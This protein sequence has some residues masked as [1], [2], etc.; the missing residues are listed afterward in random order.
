MSLVSAVNSASDTPFKTTTTSIKKETVTVLSTTETK[1]PPTTELLDEYD[2]GE[3]ESVPRVMLPPSK[4]YTKAGDQLSK[5]AIYH[6]KLK[7]GY[8]DS[9][10]NHTTVGFPD[11]ETAV[12]R[13]AIYS[14]LYPKPDMTEGPEPVSDDALSAAKSLGSYAFETMNMENRDKTAQDQLKMEKKILR[15][16]LYSINSAAKVYNNSLKPP[17]PFEKHV[18]VRKKMNLSKV[19]DGAAKRANTRIDKR[20]IPES[21]KTVQLRNKNALN[22]ANAVNATDYLPENLAQERAH[23]AELERQKME[24]YNYMTSPKVWQIATNRATSKIDSINV[25][26]PGQL[27]FGNMEYNRKAVQYAQKQFQINSQK[28]TA[29][30]EQTQ[31]KI[32]VGG[33]LWITNRDVD[34]IAR[35]Y[36]KPMMK[37]VDV[38]T[39]MERKLDRELDRRTYKYETEYEQWKQ[40]QHIRNQNDIELAGET[41]LKN[42][43]ERKQMITMGDK[44]I[45]NF[46]AQMEQ[47][48][49]QKQ[50]ELAL[51]EKKRLTLQSE[52]STKKTGLEKT[53]N[54]Q[55]AGWMKI[56][57]RDIEKLNHEES[58]LTK[59][60]YTSLTESQDTQKKL[61]DE[62]KAMHV[63]IKDL[64][65]NIQCHDRNISDLN[66][67]LELEKVPSPTDVGTVIETG[68]GRRKSII[69]IGRKENEETAK[70]KHHALLIT[71]CKQKR[72]QERLAEL[73]RKKLT[74]L[75]KEI[76][77]RENELEINKEEL[78]IKKEKLD[79]LQ[80]I[81]QSG[82][83]I[84]LVTANK[85]VTL[86]DN[87]IEDSNTAVIKRQNQ[88]AKEDDV[89]V[90]KDS[91][92]DEDEE[93]EEMEDEESNILGKIH[94]AEKAKNMGKP[95]MVTTVTLPSEN[96]NGS[97]GSTPYGSKNSIGNESVN[98]AEASASARSVTGV[99]GVMN[100]FSV[101]DKQLPQNVIKNKAW[102]N[103]I[104][105]GSRSDHEKLKLRKSYGIMSSSSPSSQ[106]TAVT[107]RENDSSS[108]KFTYQDEHSNKSS[109]VSVKDTVPS[110]SGFSQGS[111]KD[112]EEDVVQN[113]GSTQEV[114]TNSFNEDDEDAP[115]K[116]ESLFKEVF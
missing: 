31:G 70:R 48:L 75:E 83:G 32:Y 96:H 91:E 13:A 56:N 98:E 15:Q 109:S 94:T 64:R 106:P 105:I 104:F 65:N 35:G 3:D 89:N 99:S 52:L 6:A 62:I 42:E 55:L 72:E 95:T 77:V 76:S 88:I 115:V 69:S 49:A 30:I 39:D 116:K 37:K 19:L 74:V 20:Y 27:L 45:A 16:K 5:E 36:V 63:E 73:G 47:K 59:P 46:T 34:Q 44:E 110:F 50:H 103:N 11:A 86:N 24:I 102:K 38:K 57:E 12:G 10:A 108:K 111:I 112:H 114:E 71:L 85:E 29:T 87:V 9:P 92:Y 23:H 66:D 7:Y 8:Y 53:Y 22:A 28:E 18:D 54:A 14:Q 40:L 33:G 81:K 43:E 79:L 4:H 21:E 101:V 80:S 107:S 68:S 17:K 82:D 97:N 60:Y 2:Y 78:L 67:K 1:I 93:E 41:Q 51:T 100:D 58:V 61:Q 26:D 25:V 113:K 90:I 84:S